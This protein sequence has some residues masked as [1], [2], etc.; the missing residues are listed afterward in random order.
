LIVMVIEKA[1]ITTQIGGAIKDKEYP[2]IDI[3]IAGEHMCLQAEDEGVGSCMLG[4]FDEKKIKGLLNI[5]E[6]KTI[7]LIISFGYAPMDYPLRK[8]VRKDFNKVV[9]WNSY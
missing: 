4:W 7:G 3:G 9:K 5:P 1:K 8:K 6:K 2:L